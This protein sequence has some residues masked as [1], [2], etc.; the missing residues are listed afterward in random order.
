[1]EQPPSGKG[2]AVLV[3]TE[4]IPGGIDCYQTRC[5]ELGAQ[6][7]RPTHLWGKPQRDSI[8]NIDDPDKPIEN[9]SQ[10]AG[11]KERS[12]WRPRRLRDR[13]HAYWQQKCIDGFH[14]N[15]AH[16]VPTE[17]WSFLIS[18]PQA[19]PGF[20][21]RESLS[22]FRQCRSGAKSGGPYSSRIKWRL[23]QSILQR[24]QRIYIGW[25]IDQYDAKLRNASANINAHPFARIENNECRVASPIVAGQGL[26]VSA[27]GSADAY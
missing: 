22:F 13:H 7:D 4:F 12:E 10:L 2:V 17:V 24:A 16:Y 21:L 5:P 6:V 15:C 3:E 27:F 20:V 23:P 11:H 25:N 18:R 19:P 14:R 1:V 9:V 26:G 8:C